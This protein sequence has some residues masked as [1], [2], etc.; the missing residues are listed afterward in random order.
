MASAELTIPGDSAI[1]TASGSG[2][3]KHIAE[4]LAAAGVDVVVN[5]IDA[6]ALAAT[7]SEFES[8]EG[9]VTPVAGDASDPDDMAEVVETAVDE[10]GGLDILVNNVG[11]AGPSKPVEDITHEEFM[12]TL[13]V[14]LGGHFNATRAAVPHLREA[15]AGRIVNI[16]SMSGKRPLT[17]RTPY[18]TAKMGIIGFVRTLAEEVADDD[19]TVNAVC[20]GSVEG[21]RLREVIEGQAT[22][23]D[24][25]YDEV[26]A[27]F[28]AV[29]P[30]DAFTQPEDVANVVLFLCSEQA[31]HITGQDVNVTAGI[32][33]Y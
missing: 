30:L 23:E 22:N 29:S 27:E 10:F 26:E 28:R 1:V 20:P 16:S 18:T 19:V 5:D 8:L 33:K 6:D 7:A 2:I 17:Y 14:N 11:I 31:S 21:P 3:G 24:R 13:E 9:T 25:P 4:H 12:S 32:C 15:D